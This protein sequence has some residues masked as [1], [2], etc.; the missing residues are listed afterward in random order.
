MGLKLLCILTL[1]L[2]FSCNRE[3]NTDIVSPNEQTSTEMPVDVHRE[4]ARREMADIQ[5][6]AKRY[7]WHLTQTSSGLMYEIVNKHQ[8]TMPT[9]GDMVT[10][11]GTIATPAGVY[12]LD[13]HKDGAKTFQVN[14]S[15]DFVGLHELVQLMHEGDS[16]NAIVPSFLAYGIS[17]N[18]EKIAGATSLICKIK[19]ININN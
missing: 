9:A 7:N 10:I 19:L 6:I 14:R 1:L 4:I 16:L 18:G 13:S 15:D 3:K 8:G 5:L 12:V 2:C 17:G 11:A